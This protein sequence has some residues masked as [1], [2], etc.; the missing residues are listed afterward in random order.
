MSEVEAYRSRG[1]NLA[2][3]GKLK[4]AVW[5]ITALVLFL[6]GLKLKTAV[7]KALG[8]QKPEQI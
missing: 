5:V 1:A 2:L 7:L 4:I 3:A 6:V 8:P